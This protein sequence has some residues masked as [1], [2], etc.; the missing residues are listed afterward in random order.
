MDLLPGGVLGQISLLIEMKLAVHVSPG[1][2]V[3]DP[4]PRAHDGEE[5]VREEEGAKV[6]AAEVSV[7]SLLGVSHRHNS[8]MAGE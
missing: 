6:V 3:H 4:T 5:K 7:L 1:G 2:N 8:Y